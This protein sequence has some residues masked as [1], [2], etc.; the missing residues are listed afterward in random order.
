[1]KVDKVG[2]GKHSRET[3]IGKIRK[4]SKKRNTAEESKRLRAMGKRYMSLKTR[5][6]KDA[7]EVM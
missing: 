6:I 4:R 3:H 5:V 2:R 7:R 1:M